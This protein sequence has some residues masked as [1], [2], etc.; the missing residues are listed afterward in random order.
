LM[1]VFQLGSFSKT[2]PIY[3]VWRGGLLLIE[4]E[5][6]PLL[7]RAVTAAGV[8]QSLRLDSGQAPPVAT[9]VVDLKALLR[10]WRSGISAGERRRSLERTKSFGGG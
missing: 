7:T 4:A 10:G 3:G 2:N 9:E 6:S 8:R 5:M 1:G